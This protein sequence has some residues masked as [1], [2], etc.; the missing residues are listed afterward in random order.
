MDIVTASPKGSWFFELNMYKRCHKWMGENLNDVSYPVSSYLEL[1]LSSIESI[2][3]RI[4]HI[5]YELYGPV[6]WW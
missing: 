3:R 4:C 1:F 5:N 6:F 2:S